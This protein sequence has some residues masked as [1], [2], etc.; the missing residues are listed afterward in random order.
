[1]YVSWNGYLEKLTKTRSFEISK[2]NFLE[3]VNGSPSD[4]STLHTGIKRFIHEAKSLNMKICFITYDQ[5]FYIKARDITSALSKELL[6]II[7]EF[8]IRI[9]VFYRKYWSCNGR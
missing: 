4:Y 2:T 6:V 3:F 5:P 8:I 1:M 9:Y 7:V